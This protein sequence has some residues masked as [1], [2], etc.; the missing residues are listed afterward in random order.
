MRTL[1]TAI[2]AIIAVA[3]AAVLAPQPVAE[4]GSQDDDRMTMRC[5]LVGHST[6]RGKAVYK[7]RIKSNGAVR[8]RLTVKIS[9]A[10]PLRSYGVWVNGVRVGSIMTNAAGKGR[11]KLK[12]DA[13]PDLGRMAHI[14]VSSKVSG[15][16]MDQDFGPVQRYRVKAKLRGDG[17]NGL[18]GN[19]RYRERFKNGSLR[20]DFSVE[21]EDGP[22][23]TTYEVRV[24]NK[25]VAMITTNAAGFAD[26]NLRTPQHINSH[27]DNSSDDHSSDDNSS[28]D[29]D[30]SDDSSSSDSS[31][32]DDEDVQAIPG[33]FRAILPG[34]R[35]T[36]GP[37]DGKFKID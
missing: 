25:V 24:N 26:L 8:D 20:R 3:A 17:N 5:K 15:V 23:N 2:L 29:D 12:N 16:L 27:D 36:V 9:R 13:A 22:A 19:A 30:S 35:I 6:I 1:R 28:D 31:S 37:I 32:S 18:S 7:M 14:R 4:A 11:L 34:D 21:L 33:T 10:K